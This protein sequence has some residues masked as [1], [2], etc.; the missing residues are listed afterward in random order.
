MKMKIVA[1]AIAAAGATLSLV[2]LAPPAHAALDGTCNL[3][4]LCVFRF[5]TASPNTPEFDW[6]PNSGQIWNM[7]GFRFV[8]GSGLVE[9]LDESARNRYYGLNMHVCTGY[10]GTGNCDSFSFGNERSNVG[11]TYH[12]AHTLSFAS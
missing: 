12:N 8:N 4:D 7:D 1:A 3:N 9:N 10:S 2:S 5:N 6:D 11:Y